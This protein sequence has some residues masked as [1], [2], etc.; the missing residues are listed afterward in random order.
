MV[1]LLSLLFVCFFSEHGTTLEIWCWA[2]SDA[3][4]YSCICF[5]SI[6]QRLGRVWWGSGSVARETARETMNCEKPRL[7]DQSRRLAFGH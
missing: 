2:L 7:T 3:T 5:L 6:C 4:I 1:V